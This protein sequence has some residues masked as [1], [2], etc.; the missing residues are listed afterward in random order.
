MGNSVFQGGL[1]SDYNPEVQPK[2]TYRSLI[3]GLRNEAGEIINESGS[4]IIISTGKKVIGAVVL[5]EELILFSYPYEIGILSSDDTYTTKFND[6][7]LQFADGQIDA[8]ARVDFQGH[9]L[10]YYTDQVNRP[11][12][13][14]LDKVYTNLDKETRLM[15]DFSYGKFDTPLV[16]DEGAVLSGVYQASFRLLNES[17]NKTEFSLL[18]ETVSIVDDAETSTFQI[19]DG[20]PPQT[21]TSKS[22][23]FTINNID[24]SYKYLELAIVTYE[25]TANALKIY[26]ISKIPIAGRDTIT[27]PYSGANQHKSEITLNEFLTQYGRFS[28]VKCIEQKDNRLFLS[29]LS[30]QAKPEGLDIQSFVNEIEVKY[31]IDD[32]LLIYEDIDFD[33]AS[34]TDVGNDTPKTYS[35][36]NPSNSSHKKGYRRGEVISLCFTPIY[37]DGTIGRAYHIPGNNKVTVTTTAADTGTKLTGTFVSTLDYPDGYGYPVGKIRHH[38]LPTMNQEP[39]TNSFSNF[40]GGYR[41]KVLHLKVENVI[42]PPE[43]KSELA[44]YI[45]GREVRT[46]DKSSILTQGIAQPYLTN[47]GAL[48]YNGSSVNLSS[49]NDQELFLAPVSTNKFYTTDQSF[50]ENDVVP[51][52]FELEVKPK[53]AGFYSPETVILQKDMSA[54][55]SIEVVGTIIGGGIEFYTARN[56]SY[57]GERLYGVALNYK[58]YSSATS[59]IRALNT[60]E[61]RYAQESNDSEL[62]TGENG[63]H[64]FNI[65]STSSKLSIANSNGHLLLYIPDDLP[66]LDDLYVSPIPAFAPFVGPV[67]F[68]ES[69]NGDEDNVFG[70]D[71]VNSTNAEDPVTKS[72]R[73][74]YNLIKN[75]PSQ[76]GYITDSEY[77]V[78]DWK[79]FNGTDEEF[80][81]FGGDTYINKF[82]VNSSTQEVNIPERNILTL[83]M[84]VNTIHYYFTESSINTDLRHSIPVD[85][86]KKGSLPYYPRYK[87]FRNATSTGLLDFRGS[88][89]HSKEYNKQYSFENI[90]VKLTPFQLEERPINDFKNRTVY[91]ELLSEGQQIDQY[92]VFLPNNY[93][94]I[95]KAK[96]EI[97]DSFIYQ[98]TLYLQTPQSLFRTF[99]NDI[100]TQLTSLGEVYLG[101]GGLFPRPSIEVMTLAGG[102]AGTKSQFA[103]CNTPFGR[104]MID[105]LQGK[106][107]LLTDSLEEISDKGNFNYF[108]SKVTSTVDNPS[109]GVGYISAYDYQ[110]KRWILTGNGSVPGDRFTVS[111]TPK[112]Q[113]WSSTHTYY[114]RYLISK[115]KRL[116]GMNTTE[117]HEMNVG[118]KGLYLSSEEPE[119]MEIIYIFNEDVLVNKTLDNLV[120]LSVSELDGVEFPTDTFNHIQC[121]NNMRNSGVIDIIN[122]ELTPSYTQVKVR[123]VNEEFRLAVPRDYV[124]D[125][126]GDIFEPTNLSSSFGDENS[127]KYFRPRMRGKYVAVKLTYDNL[128]N[129]TLTLYTI[130]NKSRVTYR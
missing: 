62:T 16:K 46:T 101:S 65:T 13:I 127:D 61:T 130:T 10:I 18:S 129:N 128:T 55:T 56:D 63:S 90:L 110:N 84:R 79:I 111:Y 60:T 107:F 30:T 72:Q 44:G 88:M 24:T 38:K 115:G 91:S 83:G 119:V 74:I 105:N 89:G 66:I 17:L 85:V 34:G 73:Y 86:S 92:R 112:L 36:K 47:T 82:Y 78:C 98:N 68:E 57:R 12:V 109:N 14:D 77:I 49:E 37:L 52:V 7:I 29:N 41:P 58:D 1:Y 59:I 35:Y 64:Y 102:Y 95:P 53:I 22:I 76:Y 87:I 6:A 108:L 80:S 31:Q 23:D 28:R 42:I 9:R 2:G 48:F 103:G 117:I 70:N 106:V 118:G 39:I 51:V 94:D 4:E 75:N 50:S 69:P 20:C 116:F 100:A 123:K 67:L 19:Y 126:S 71:G 125:P 8:Q 26:L 124:I 11:R 45:I 21:P 25:G 81:F 104:F 122:D 97:W 99:V 93:H 5:G 113:S 54:A 32:S 40:D 120:I 27:I 96:G 43:I 114:P 121:Y 33:L 3:N 15:L